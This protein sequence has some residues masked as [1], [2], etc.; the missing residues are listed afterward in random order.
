MIDYNPPERSDLNIRRSL[1]DVRLF[2]LVP[3]MMDTG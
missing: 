3:F 2:D 1:F